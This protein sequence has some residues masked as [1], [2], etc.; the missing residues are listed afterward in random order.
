ME[1]RIRTSDPGLGCLKG[2]GEDVGETPRRS[3]GVYS[4]IHKVLGHPITLTH[5]LAL[6]SSVIEMK[7][8]NDVWRARQGV[9]SEKK[10][11]C[12]LT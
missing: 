9:P 6:N 3:A 5:G 4:S 1:Q 11:A 10:F 7:A 12:F 8:K 2:V